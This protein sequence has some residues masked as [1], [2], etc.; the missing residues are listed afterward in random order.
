MSDTDSLTDLLLAQSE[1]KLDKMRD[2]IEAQIRTLQ[3]QLGIVEDALNRK[4][5]KK[6]SE[7]NRDN[8]HGVEGRKGFPRASLLA[9]V[10]TFDSPFRPAEARDLLKREGIELRV[11]AVRNGLVRLERDGSLERLEDGRYVV[12]SHHHRREEIE[13]DPEGTGSGLEGQS[14]LTE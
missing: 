5:S 2:N 3:V 13:T 4:R 8:G 10:Q 6:R 14:A 11:E 1:R 12:V 7:P 9:H